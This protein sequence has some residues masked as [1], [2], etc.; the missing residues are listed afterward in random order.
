[1]L[2]PLDVVCF[3]SFSS[4]YSTKLTDH[5]VE[6]QGLLAVQKEDFFLQFWSAW[7]SFLATKLVRRAFEA[8]G[9]CPMN[10]YVVVQ[11][12]SNKDN[13][14]S[15]PR[16][17]ALLPTEWRQMVRLIRS[18]VKYT[19][20]EDSQK[21]S[22]TLHLLQVQNEVLQYDNNG[23]RDTLTA[24]KQRKAVGKPSDLQYEES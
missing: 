8:T 1:M 22:R 15:E 14:E 6:T 17:T 21:L 24:K 10:A 7:E 20:A 11:G 18:A 4:S 16:P 2:Q 19:A 23:L 5:L 3:K 13:D 9:I 12:F